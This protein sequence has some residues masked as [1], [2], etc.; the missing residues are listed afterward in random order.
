[1]F[2]FFE[3]G[4][5]YLKHQGSKEINC[6]AQ[7]DLKVAAILTGSHQTSTWL[8][9]SNE[10]TKYLHHAIDFYGSKAVIENLFTALH[11]PIDSLEYT[12]TE[13]TLSL[14]H[15]GKSAKIIAKSRDGQIINIGWLG[16]LHPA[17]AKEMD[18]NQETFLFELEIENLKQ[19]HHNPKFETIASLPPIN[20]DLT[21]DLN[22]DID[23][24]A[25][26]KNIE[27]SA[28]NLKKL[29]LVS[30]FPLNDTFKSLSYRLTFQNDNDT[31]KSEEVEKVLNKVRQN[32]KEKL[33]ASFRT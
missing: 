4:F 16:Q 3:I 12:R 32:L 26:I 10:K 11:I 9:A 18:L 6:P 15:P 19:L 25:V 27:Q 30:I 2:G 24:A 33:S 14:L 7:E 1:M 5:T 31:L 13:P 21:V 8:D 22:K 20:R 23:N 28:T 29:E 17:H